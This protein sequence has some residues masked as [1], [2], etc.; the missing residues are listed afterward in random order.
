VRMSKTFA[1]K[2]KFFVNYG[3]SVRTR[4]TGLSEHFADR[5]EGGGQFLRVCVNVVY[6][7]SL[8]FE[9]N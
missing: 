9:L 5:G 6:E 2:T 4:E 1:A 7:H 3:V 8:R